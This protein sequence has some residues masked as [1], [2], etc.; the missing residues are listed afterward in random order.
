MNDL[1]EKLPSSDEIALAHESAQVLAAYVRDQAL[2][3]TLHSPKHGMRQLQLPQRALKLLL[4]MLTHMQDGKAVTLVPHGF[5]LTTQ[6]A[7]DLLN[8]SRPFF[9]GLLRSGAM[10]Y[11]KVGTHRR[12]RYNDVMAYREA[13]L[14]DSESAV[15][16]LTQIGQ[17]DGEY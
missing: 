5:E 4:E 9:V 16:E 13:Q 14:Q 10:P 1:A 11:H 17:E 12:V 2:E 7:A 8:V 15:D 6:Q 3:L